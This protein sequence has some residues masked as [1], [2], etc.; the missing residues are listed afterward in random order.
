MNID[1]FTFNKR[2]P[3]DEIATGCGRKFRSHA[4]ARVI[5]HFVDPLSL[6]FLVVECSLRPRLACS[7]HLRLQAKTV[8]QARNMLRETP[9]TPRTCPTAVSRLKKAAQWQ[10]PLRRSTSRFSSKL[11]STHL[12][13]LIKIFT[14]IRQELR[15]RWMIHR[16]YTQYFFRQIVLP[17]LQ[18][19]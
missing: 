10:N 19:F 3:L 8:T 14:C 7:A 1:F 6:L 13:S 5:A 2:H 12:I 4:P 17:L 16:F 11:Q 15:I 18:I 9:A